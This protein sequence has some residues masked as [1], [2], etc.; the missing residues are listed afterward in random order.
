MHTNILTARSR[1]LEAARRPE[2][3]TGGA[4][5]VDLQDEE[6]ETFS[7]YLTCVYLGIEALHLGDDAPQDKR[8]DDGSE[9]K[10]EIDVFDSPEIEYAARYK[11]KVEERSEYSRYAVEVLH[12]LVKLYLLADRLQDS[13]TANLVIDEYIRFANEAKWLPEVRTIILSYESTTHG[14]PL[15]KL[16]RDDCVY[17]TVSAEYIDLHFGEYP[18]EF[19]R[20]VTVEYTRIKNLSRTSAEKHIWHCHEDK[21]WELVDKCHYH[22]HDDKHPRCVLKPVQGDAAGDSTT[23][24]QAEAQET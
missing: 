15:R 23:T 12:I 16:M 4:K 21:D 22:Q 6:P 11:A 1:F 14:H 19:T 9:P 24:L 20:D 10:L 18:S 8:N 13:K 7:R 5:P 3:L 2:W 17:E